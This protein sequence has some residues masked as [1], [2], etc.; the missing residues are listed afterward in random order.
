M[1]FRPKPPTFEGEQ[2]LPDNLSGM[3]GKFRQFVCA[4]MCPTR[5]PDG[6]AHI[7]GAGV[8][9]ALAGGDWIIQAPDGT[10]SICRD[11]D[12]HATYEK[13]TE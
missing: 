12:L 5:M 11:A 1:K 3:S 13:V 2:Y 8:P 7:H 9:Q 6:I 10:L 4:E